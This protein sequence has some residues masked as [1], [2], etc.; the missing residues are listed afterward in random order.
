MTTGQFNA[1]NTKMDSILE[2][3]KASYSNDYSQAS[4]KAFFKTLT[5]EPTS[6]LALTDNA[7][8]DSKNT[9]KETT[10]K[11]DKLF[12]DI[13]SFME[14]FLSSS[15]RNTTSVD[16]TI[17]SLVSS[18]QTEKDA[19]TK[20]RSYIQTDNSEIQTSISS[21]ID[22]LYVDLAHENKIMD[23]LAIKTDR[24]KVLLVM[25]MHVNSHIADLKSENVVIQSCIANVKSNLHNLIET[26]NSLLTVSVRQHLVEK[27]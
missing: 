23:E 12:S 1:L 7:V 27:L 2:S 3:T 19:L 20:V 21:M 22:K 10:K 16:T 9:S 18:L 13:K 15:E 14:E 4:V 26:H 25:L 8:A 11:V 24:V 5:K 17:N 6:N